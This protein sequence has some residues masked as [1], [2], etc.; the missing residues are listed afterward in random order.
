[1]ATSPVISERPY[2]VLF[3]GVLAT[4]WFSGIG[5]A[6]FAAGLSAL[7][8][9]FYLYPA[10]GGTAPYLSVTLFLALSSA[11]A[12]ALDSWRRALRRATGAR[13]GGRASGGERGAGRDAAEGATGG[14][15]G[16]LAR[17]SHETRTPMNAVIGMASVLLDTPLSGHQR[18]LIQTIRNSSDALLVLLNDVLDFS[19]IESGRLEVEI[20]PLDLRAC[21]E[22][23]IDLL[24]PGRAPPGRPGPQPRGG[25][26]CGRGPAASGPP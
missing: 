6:L 12:G 9:F 24:A 15:R 11:L 23:A 3:A 17:G 7:V 10:S 14:K 20:E 13:E 4:A 19:K 18:E 22:S 16:S 8:G 2:M 1:A 25:P 26:R 5:P 21:V